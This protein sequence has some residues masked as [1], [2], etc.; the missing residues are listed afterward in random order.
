LLGDPFSSE[1]GDGSIAS[2]SG[3]AST[4]GEA[5]DS[6][7][8][9]VS[10]VVDVGGGE[11]G[12]STVSLADSGSLFSGTDLVALEE[13][14]SSGIVLFDVL[15]A[16]V[17]VS[18]G[19][20]DELENARGVILD[21]SVSSAVNSL[22]SFG[23]RSGEGNGSKGV[24]KSQRIVETKDGRVIDQCGIIV[25]RMDG[26]HL[27]DSDVGGVA[28]VDVDV[29]VDDS[30][31]RSGGD[32]VS[33]ETDVEGIEDES[34]AGSNVVAFFDD[35]VDDELELAGFGQSSSEDRRM[36]R[37]GRRGREKDDGESEES[38]NGSHFV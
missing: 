9:G 11:Q 5:G 14:S 20:G 25:Q 30:D 12:A 1:A 35:D 6:D 4:E 13:A 38:D 22:P 24:S 2:V 27:G 21:L 16:V 10:W 18:Q 37:Q 26:E 29:V 33:S 15:V 31:L 28:I 17:E 3:S 7:G 23:Q 19:N 8:L 32:T 36:L 34:G